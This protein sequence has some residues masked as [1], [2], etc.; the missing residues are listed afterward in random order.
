MRISN[1]SIAAQHS[2]DGSHVSCLQV[3]TAKQPS[4]PREYINKSAAFINKRCGL[5]NHEYGMASLSLFVDRKISIQAKHQM[6]GVYLYYGN[7]IHCTSAG[8]YFCKV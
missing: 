7:S 6:C 1:C 5:N 4:S 2:I 8:G 3:E